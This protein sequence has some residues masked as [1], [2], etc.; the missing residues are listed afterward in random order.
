[1]CEMFLLRVNKKNPVEYIWEG[2]GFP[3]EEE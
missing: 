3:L 2:N 1:V